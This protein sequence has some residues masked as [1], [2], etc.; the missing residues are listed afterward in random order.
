MSRLLRVFGVGVLVVSAAGYT[1]TEYIT[2]TLPTPTPPSPYGTEPPPPDCSQP[3]ERPADCPLPDA[4]CPPRA[5]PTGPGGPAFKAEP[6]G[7]PAVTAHT[8]T[9]TVRPPGTTHGYTCDRA[10]SVVISR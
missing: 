7:P 9:E 1:A 3:E 4:G 5:T 8:F 10:T 6:S 2:S